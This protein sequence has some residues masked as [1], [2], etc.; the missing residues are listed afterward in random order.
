MYA[1]SRI[2]V[3][4]DGVAVENADGVAS[5]SE[6]SLTLRSKGGAINITGEK[7]IIISMEDGAV[8]VGGRIHS[9]SLL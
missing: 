6:Q 3:T 7:L 9:V 2:I 4:A 5:F 8:T 1:N